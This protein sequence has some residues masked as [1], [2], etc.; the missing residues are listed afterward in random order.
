MIFIILM[1][2]AHKYNVF[3]RFVTI[4]SILKLQT[5]TLL[6]TRRALVLP[7]ASVFVVLHDVL[8]GLL[9]NTICRHL[10]VSAH[11]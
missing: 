6:E 4:Q 5:C 10:R 11:Q 1:V 8:S 2:I 9:R 3:I 7:S